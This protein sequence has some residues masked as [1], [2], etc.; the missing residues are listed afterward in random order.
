MP[1]GAS[2]SAGIAAHSVWGISGYGLRELG[3][4]PAQEC[5]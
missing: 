5:P 1:A 3:V 2:A 4:G